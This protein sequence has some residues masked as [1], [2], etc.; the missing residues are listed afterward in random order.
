MKLATRDDGSRDG[1][2]LVV[3]PPLVRAVEARAC[4]SV[5]DALRNWDAA[6]RELRAEHAALA[7]GDTTDSVVFEPGACR[8][9]VPVAPALVAAPAPAVRFAAADDAGGLA[10]EA[11]VAVVTGPV[12]QGCDRAHAVAAIRLVTLAATVR[13]PGGDP[14]RWVF[15]PVAV[16]PDALDEA[17]QDGVL[18][19]TVELAAA[20]DATLGEAPQAVLEVDAAA[21][22]VAA[23]R[24][25]ELP[26]GAVCGPVDPAAAT[27]GAGQGGAPLRVE[28]RDGLGRSLFGPI[29]LAARG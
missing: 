2:L 1:R 16:T 8:P 9:I 25:R 5:L 17:W 24:D 27:G 15:A 19:G 13:P 14:P 23:A 4:T 12:P 22:I 20:A 11:E 28:M 21:R 29:A 7:A 18:T 6:E 26:A 10:A 3:D